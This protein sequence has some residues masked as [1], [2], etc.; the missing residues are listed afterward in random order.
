MIRFSLRRLAVRAFSIPLTPISARPRSI[1]TLISSASR[2]NRPSFI[3]PSLQRG[4]ASEHEQYGEDSFD[5]GEISSADHSSSPSA[6]EFRDQSS[7]VGSTRDPVP[8]TTLY[9]GNIFFDTELADVQRHFEKA[10]AIKEVKIIKD[11]RGL[12]KG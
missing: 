2:L 11:Q 1:T 8:C 10:G 12:S 3:L 5:D 9:V 4:F 6:S 7:Y